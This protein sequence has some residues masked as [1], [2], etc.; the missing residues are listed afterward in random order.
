MP[1]YTHLRRA[2]PI[3][4]A[5]FFLAHAAALRRDVGRFERAIDEADEM[6]LG[7]GAIA[8]TTYAVDTAA[9]A[10]RL[11]FSRIVA[12]QPRRHVRPRLRRELPARLR[13]SRWCT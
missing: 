8:G 10:G 12:Q 4:V 7:S 3:L 9:L 11:G 5:H 6:P 13:R 2:Q 1:S